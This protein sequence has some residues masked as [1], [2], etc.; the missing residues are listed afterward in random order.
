M[1]RA[2]IKSI[3]KNAAYLSVAKAVASF[4]RVIYAIALAKFLGPELYGMFNLGMSWY[5]LFLPISMLGLDSILIREV[6]RDRSSASTLIGHALALRGLSGFLTSLICFLLGFFL[7]T[8][9]TAKLLLFIFSLALFGRSLSF[10]VYAIFK[11]YEQS[12]HVF[13]QETSFRLLEVLLGLAL[14]LSGGG[15]IGIALVHASIWLVQGLLGLYFVRKHI[16]RVMPTWDRPA[17][18]HLL[19]QGLPFVISAFLVAWVM[20]GGTLVYR[21][22]E[23]YTAELGMFA[24]AMQA[25]LILG[26]IVAELSAAALPVLS[27][28]VGRDDGKSGFYIDV[29]LRSGF[30]LGGVLTISGIALGPLIVDWIFGV[31][32]QQV[33]VLL[34]WTL[35]WVVAYFFMTNLNSV[36]IAI[37]NYGW[38]AWVNLVGAIA[39]TLVVFPLHYY[40]GILG[41]VWATGIGLFAVNVSQLYLVRRYY[42]IDFDRAVLRP[43]GVVMGGILLSANLSGMN[44][45]GVLLFGL[46]VL[47]LATLVTGVIRKAEIQHILGFIG[48]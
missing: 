34:P 22:L 29:I 25:L 24:L 13:R 10:W 48:K 39:F 4:S 28:S 41:V 23:G 27:R 35:F 30:L 9:S 19:K 20:Q 33:A 36:I 37:G 26:G 21:G 45:W 18:L 47:V 17:I 38:I 6:G 11:A 32:Y 1:S 31:Q 43:I 12:V 15:L 8:N 14:L 42:R 44:D 3:A 46:L 16:V 40:F 7:E 2:G 5:L